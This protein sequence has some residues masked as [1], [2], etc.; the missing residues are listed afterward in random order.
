MAAALA[1]ECS[2]SSDA[3]AEAAGPQVVRLEPQVPLPPGATRAGAPGPGPR[4]PAR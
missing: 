1:T 4:L 2:E 3:K